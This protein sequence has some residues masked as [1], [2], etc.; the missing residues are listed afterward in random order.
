MV[1]FIVRHHL[2][3]NSGEFFNIDFMEAVLFIKAV[4]A[5]SISTVPK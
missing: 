1:E 4:A 2:W 5:L 3:E